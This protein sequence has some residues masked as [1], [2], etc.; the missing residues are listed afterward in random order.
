MQVSE[1]LCITSTHMSTKPR[2][3]CLWG[4]GLEAAVSS[5]DSRTSQRN[6]RSKVRT[7]ARRTA[8]AWDSF[9]PDLAVPQNP[10]GINS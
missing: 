7:S 3:V 4:R 8:V 9:S 2:S 1:L 6:N 10:G 5:C